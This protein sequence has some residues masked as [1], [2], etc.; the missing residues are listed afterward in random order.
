MPLDRLSVQDHQ[1]L[2]L[3]RGEIRGHTCKLIILEPFDGRAPPSIEQLREHL[4]ATLYAAPRLRRR[5]APTPVAIAPPVWVDDPEFDIARHVRRVAT[6][7]PADRPELLEIVG[8]L[9]S[10]RLDREHPLW[11]LDVVSLDDGGEALIW[12]IHHCM[13]DGATAVRLGKALLWSEDPDAPDRPPSSWR[14]ARTPGTAS[15][16]AGGA[17]WRA[18]HLR[19]ERR[20]RGTSPRASRAALSRELARTGATTPLAAPIGHGRIIALASAPLS[21]CKRAGKA[22]APKVTLNDVVLAIV[23]GG[24]RAW[25]EHRAGAT[26][27]IRVK[28]PVSL[29]HSDEAAGVGNRDSYFFVDL[30]VA[31]PDPVKRL[32]AING[33]TAER[34]LDR[35]AEWLYRLGLHRSVAR[36]A[37]S[38]HVFT[39]NVSNVPGP[40]NDIYVLGARVR[41]LYF[42]A[43]IAQHHALR[44]SVISAAGTLFFGLCA[45]RDA[46]PDLDV[47]TDGLD[48]ARDS[49]LR[50]CL[51]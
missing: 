30:P 42:I 28:V 14:P 19:R 46:V 34:K 10:E 13:A 18:R 7:A 24:V 43:E 35:D 16:L 47:L 6:Q 41:E 29:H 11:R 23:S 21:E 44:I 3:E 36:W 20:G 33:E 38:P 5:L 50:Q 31:E 2:R 48:E 4:D 25:L 8:R 40:R 39:F 1:I 17:A 9:M 22:I 12:R 49:L 15:L 51:S 45:D 27:G 37:M 26:E 32:L